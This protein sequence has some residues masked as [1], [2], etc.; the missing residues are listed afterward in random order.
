MVKRAMS[1]ERATFQTISMYM[2]SSGLGRLLFDNG[3]MTRS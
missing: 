3:I 2:A 1:V